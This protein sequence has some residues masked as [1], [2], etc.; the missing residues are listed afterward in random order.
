MKMV[1][2]KNGKI[3]KI[4]CNETGE[5]YYGSTTRKLCDRMTDHRRGYRF[6]LEG[7][8]VGKCQSSC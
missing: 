7:N 8:N 2:Y 5:V 6:W 1:N 4:E 3:Y